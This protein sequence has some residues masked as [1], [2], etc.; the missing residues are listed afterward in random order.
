MLVM[1]IA[2]FIVSLLLAPLTVWYAVVVWLRNCMFDCGLLHSHPTPVPSVGI[3]NLSVGGSGKTPHTDYVIGH[4]SKKFSTA[5]VSRGYGRNTKGFRQVDV[6]CRATEVGDEPLMLKR[7]HPDIQAAVCEQRKEAVE[8]LYA[9]HDDL[10]LFV[11]DDVFQHRYIRPTVSVLLTEYD[12]P[13]FRDAILPFGNLREPRRHCSRADIVVV[14]KSPQNVANEEK[15]RFAKDLCI[16]EKQELFFS[17]M[18]YGDVVDIRS[19]CPAVI[20]DYDSLLVVTGIAHPQ[21]L[22]EYL[23]GKHRVVVHM[24]FSDHHGF[25]RLDIDHIVQK[26]KSLG[27]TK[28]AIVTTEK[29]AMR[30]M[31]FAD[32]KPLLG[33]PMFYQSIEVVFHDEDKFL[34][35]LNRRLGIHND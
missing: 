28:N 2:R 32:E 27:K 21:P 35:S 13:Y 12:K 18:V 8:K 34:V 11:F 26:Y 6:C 9:Q 30:L 20:D 23:C 19:G 33:I 4:L 7:R 24:S 29:D 16:S 1:K 14:T 15:E 10:E 25:T 5:L 22:V 17:S 31:T 3:G